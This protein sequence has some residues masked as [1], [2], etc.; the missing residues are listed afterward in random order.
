MWNIITVDGYF[1][2]N[3]SWDLP[4]HELVWSE[5]LEDFSIAQL[6]SADALLF[7]RV[8]YE[9]MAKYWSA[10]TGVIA[11][12]MNSLTK[13]V[14]SKTLKKAEW[15][16]SR[17]IDSA[18][19]EAI[20]NLKTI[21]EKDIYIFGSSMLVQKLIELGLID[22]YRIGIAPHIHGSGSLLFKPGLPEVDLRLIKIQRMKNDALVITYQPKK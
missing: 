16:N 12:Y 2:G 20:I 6:G 14:I 9:G 7:G 11:D 21:L 1:E 5:E 8:T 3:A 17:V 19:D 4:W 22:E 13:Y 18:I 15:K 10:E